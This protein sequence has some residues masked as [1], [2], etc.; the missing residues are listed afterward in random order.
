MNSPADDYGRQPGALGPGADGKDRPLRVCMV[1]DYYYPHVGGVAE[2]IRH[3]S[4]ELHRRGHTVRVLTA[5]MPVT[6]SSAWCPARPEVERIGRGILVP[7]NGS[8]ARIV[9]AWDPVRK[10]RN[11]IRAGR[12]DIIHIHGSLAPTLPLA[13]LH[14]AAGLRPRPATVMTFHAGHNRNAGYALFRP[15][16]TRYFRLI[17]CPIAVSRAARWSTSLYF[18]GRYEIVPNGIDTAVFRPNLPPPATIRPG[19]PRILFMGRFDP[20]KGLMHLIDA[21][22]AVLRQFPDAELIVAGT[23]PPDPGHYLA[24]LDPVHRPAVRF[25]GTVWGDDRA[26]WYSACDVFCAPST[27]NESF[28]IILLE[29]MA[30]GRPIVASDIHGYR[31]VLTDGVQGLLCPPADPAAIA[32]R[33][34]RLLAN[35]ELAARMGRAGRERALN[36]AWPRIADRIEEIYRRLVSRQ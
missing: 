6:G 11:S 12:Y 30:A 20:R 18:P 13:T 25:I 33:I 28:G 24:R 15:L 19:R 29:A 17:D 7:T 34:C 27:G 5:R 4:D 16:L 31:E 35:P 14:A 8:R 2:H 1:C 3:L 32:D 10:V 22:P 36:Y 21:L 26:A 9:A 23:G